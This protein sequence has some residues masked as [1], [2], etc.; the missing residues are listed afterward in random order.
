M[1][2]ISQESSLANQTGK[3]CIDE[4]LVRSWKAVAMMTW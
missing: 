1:Y 3:E 4:S 2:N